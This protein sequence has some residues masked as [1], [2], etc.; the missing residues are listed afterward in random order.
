[1]LLWPRVKFGLSEKQ[2]KFEKN[3]LMVLTNQ[4]I[5]LNS[6]CHNHK[7]FFF[8]LHMCASQKVWTLLLECGIRKYSMHIILTVSI[9][10]NLFQGCVT[11]SPHNSQHCELI[12]LT[13]QG[14]TVLKSLQNEDLNFLFVCSFWSQ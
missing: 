2:T 5:Y 10:E 9:G 11:R 1:M 4:L 8:K 12:C 7:D 6:K 3:F 13:I 14:H